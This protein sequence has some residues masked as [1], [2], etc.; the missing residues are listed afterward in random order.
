[1]AKKISEYIS[2]Y[3]YYP[4]FFQIDCAGYSVPHMCAC[5]AVYNKAKEIKYFLWANSHKC[6]KFVVLSKEEGLQKL[7]AQNKLWI[8]FACGGIVDKYYVPQSRYVI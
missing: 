4:T 5:Y 8:N 2:E 3:R 6:G 1:M 7:R